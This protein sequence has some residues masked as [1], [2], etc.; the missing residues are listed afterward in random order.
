MKALAYIFGIVFGVAL[1]LV[2]VRLLTSDGFDSREYTLLQ[3]GMV[4]GGATVVGLLAGIP[5][6]VAGQR[7]H[8][9]AGAIGLCGFLGVVLF[10]A[11]IVALVW[12]LTAVERRAA[13]CAKCGYDLRGLTGGCP[14]CG[15]AR[16]VP[17][18]PDE[19]GWFKIS[20]VDL[21]TQM[22]TAVTLYANSA[23]NAAAKA[24]LQGVVVTRVS[25]T[26]GRLTA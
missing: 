11:W 10:P 1:F 17:V 19:P 15:T 18:A 22:D 4:I 16:R 9:Q 8:P 6:F 26:I 13:T 21:E 24:E 12:A 7:G 25:R 14:E 2:C 3:M 5:G 20:G 23:A